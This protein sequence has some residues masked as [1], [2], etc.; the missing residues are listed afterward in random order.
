MQATKESLQDYLNVY[1]L[2]DESFTISEQVSIAFEDDTLLQFNIHPTALR[3][4][5]FKKSKRECDIEMGR[6]HE[7]PEGFS[8]SNITFDFPSIIFSNK[9]STFSYHVTSFL[10]QPMVVFEFENLLACYSANAKIMIQRRHQALTSHTRIM[11]E[12]VSNAIQHLKQLESL[13]HYESYTFD[14][15]SLSVLKLHDATFWIA[16]NHKVGNGRLSSESEDWTF[17]LFPERLV[18]SGKDVDQEVGLN[19]EMIK[20]GSH[21]IP[22]TCIV[23]VAYRHAPS[24][25]YGNTSMVGPDPQDVFWMPPE[26]VNTEGCDMVDSA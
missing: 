13:Q 26:Q 3:I 18:I 10:Q 19:K 21:S 9:I 12:S 23:P 14:L 24:E 7:I 5:H 4:D 22:L 1:K 11:K 25:W 2:S 8:I 16:F 20:F 17:Q 6:S 15:M